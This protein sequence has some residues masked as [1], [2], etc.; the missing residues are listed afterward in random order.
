MLRS[1]KLVLFFS[2]VDL[3]V[4]D[5]GLSDSICF[6]KLWSMSTSGQIP[7]IFRSFHSRK[8]LTGGSLFLDSFLFPLSTA[9]SAQ[10]FLNDQNRRPN[11]IFY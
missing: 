2:L 3:Q 6:P 7:S 4:P 9:P 5:F 1:A 11:A 8:F 10:V